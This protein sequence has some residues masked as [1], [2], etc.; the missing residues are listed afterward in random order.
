MERNEIVRRALQG[1]AKV[2]FSA[3]LV[4]CGGITVVPN[5]DGEGGQGGEGA[6]ASTTGVTT[7]GTTA[8]TTAA[9]TIAATS[10]AS[11]TSTGPGG[12]V[13]GVESM[14][15]YADGVV[16]CCTS[17]LITTFPPDGPVDPRPT[18]GSPDLVACCDVGLYVYDNDLMSQEPTSPIPWMSVYPCCQIEGV[19]ITEP[20]SVACSPWGPPPPPAMIEDLDWLEEAA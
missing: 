14:P 13:C 16:D 2:A 20:F 1:A 8:S 12:G 17:M 9:T 7:V 3:A 4:G 10:V 15:P 18:M 19:H 11:T 5:P 6:T